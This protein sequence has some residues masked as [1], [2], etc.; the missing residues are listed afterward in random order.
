[1]N[2][3]DFDELVRGALTTETPAEQLV[4][5]E[6]FWRR[7]SQA[8]QAQRRVSRWRVVAL[9]AS[10]L[11][12]ASV[13]MWLWSRPMQLRPK[14]A[15]AE[16]SR[17]PGVAAVAADEDGATSLPSES[18][19]SQRSAGRPATA[20]EQLMFAMSSARSADAETASL[21]TAIDKA[22]EQLSSDPTADV[23]QA[24]LPTGVNPATA[25]PRLLRRLSDAKGDQRLPVLKLLAVWGTHHSTPALLRAARDEPL[26]REALATLEHIVGP[27]GLA[28]AATKAADPAVRTAIYRRLLAAD[29]PVAL[30]SYLSLVS[31]KT[32]R[33]EALSAADKVAQPP[34]DTL[35]TLLTDEDKHVRV[36]AALVLGRLNGPDVTAALI[37]LVAE[38]PSAPPEAW[39]ALLSCRGE[40]ADRFLADASR[41]P[42]M[43]GHVNNARLFWARMIQ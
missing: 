26:R 36:S 24:E 1:M 32:F 37:A 27:E 23:R 38:N 34:L 19:K 6:Q 12:V 10:V 15:V 9:A 17:Q 25:E 39:V 42:R 20:Y 31:D 29:S 5:L 4:R 14:D 30:R 41:H 16:R 21:T 11:L 13:G 28:M 18:A 35:L 8:Q 43:L 40:S 7:R 3:R 33:A 2:E 22:I